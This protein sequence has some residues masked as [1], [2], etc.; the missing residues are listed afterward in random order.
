M[1]PQRWLEGQ[2]L[3]NATGETQAV[4]LAG[5]GSNG[6]FQLMGRGAFPCS[7][8]METFLRTDVRETRMKAWR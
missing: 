1:S 6:G 3:E 7:I 5:Q 2:N 8:S 4:K